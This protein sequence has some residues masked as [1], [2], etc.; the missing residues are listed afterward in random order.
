[1]PATLPRPLLGWP[2]L[3]VP[4]ENG[5]LAFPSVEASVRQA[6]QIILRTR[7]GEQ[8]RRPTFGAG[9]EEFVHEQNT[10]ATRRRIRDVISES[11]NRWEPRIT[12]DRVSVFDDPQRPTHVRVV[13]AYRLRR[14]GAAQQLGLSITLE[15]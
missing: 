15:G 6:I 12:L 1:M 13:I 7:P 14:T 9:L 3:P 10:L 2:L 4:D 8:L 5:Q 11:L